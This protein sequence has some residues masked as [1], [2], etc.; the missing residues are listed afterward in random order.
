MRNYVNL[1]KIQSL[2]KI[3]FRIAR[4]W[5][6]KLDFEYKN[7]KR[8]IFVDGHKQ[9]DMVE[10]RRKISKY[11]K[12]LKPYLVEFKEKGLMKTKKYPDDY[13]IEED[14]YCL[15]IVITHDKCIFFAN[16]GI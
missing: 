6:Y 10:D 4:N 11:N 5:L 13:A 2:I 15:V 7:I 14:K 12:D 1:K 9:P 3:K 8:N 16:D